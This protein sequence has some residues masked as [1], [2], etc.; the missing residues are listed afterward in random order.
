MYGVDLSEISDESLNELCC[1][2]EPG[3]DCNDNQ[4]HLLNAPV[5]S[6]NLLNQIN[7]LQENWIRFYDQSKKKILINATQKV[8]LI[9]KLNIQTIIIM[10]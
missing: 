1:K 10:Q 8:I 9:Q 7:E 3:S 5:V 2:Q 6:C 4:L